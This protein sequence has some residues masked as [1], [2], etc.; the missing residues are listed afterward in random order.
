MQRP[1]GEFV[2]E[3]CSV[4]HKPIGREF[5]GEVTGLATQEFLHV[6]C[7]QARI[8]CP[9]TGKNCFDKPD[10]HTACSR[11]FDSTPTE[12]A[13]IQELVWRAAQDD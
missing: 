11:C 8:A 4:C 7:L 12:D 10:A 2:G 3:L 13:D 5:G 9:V 1:D 6:D